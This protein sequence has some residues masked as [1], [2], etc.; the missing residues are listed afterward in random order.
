MIKRIASWLNRPSAYENGKLRY[1]IARDPI[2]TLLELK[3]IP[4]DFVRRVL[5]IICKSFDIPGSQMY[6]LR[7]EDNLADIYRTFVE[8]SLF[9]ISD[10]MEYER[11]YFGLEEMLGDFEPKDLSPD[12][13]VT[14]QRVI[15]FAFQKYT[16]HPT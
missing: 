16:S 6:C 10:D 9:G 7:L 12:I 4:F 8:G 2:P 11:L 3:G 1:L 15:E 13:N 5:S 14:V